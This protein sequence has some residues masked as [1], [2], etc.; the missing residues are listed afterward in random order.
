MKISKKIRR[1]IGGEN[2]YEIPQERAEKEKK[3]FLN[4]RKNKEKEQAMYV[5]W[6]TGSE[7]YEEDADDIALMAIEESEPE[8]DSNS[9][10]K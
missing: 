8:P 3:E 4:T 6:G 7:M 10:E 1:N 5:A 2:S 9:K